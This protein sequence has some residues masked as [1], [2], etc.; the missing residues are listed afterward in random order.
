MEEY[1]RQ[2]VKNIVVC[3]KENLFQQQQLGLFKLLA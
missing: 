1:K 2:R 3:A